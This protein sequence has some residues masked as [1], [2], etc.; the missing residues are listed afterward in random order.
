[1]RQKSHPCLYFC[2]PGGIRWQQPRYGRESGAALRSPSV[3]LGFTCTEPFETHLAL[4]PFAQLCQTPLLTPSFH[5]LPTFCHCMELPPV[6]PFCSPQLVISWQTP[7]AVLPSWRQSFCTCGAS[8]V[9]G[10]F[11]CL[12]VLLLP[13]ERILC[14]WGTGLA[15]PQFRTTTAAWALAA[16][17]AQSTSRSFAAFWSLGRRNLFP[18]LS[19]FI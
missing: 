18:A 6:A 1:M 3:L 12:C 11:L 2:F 14:G 7:P 16:L 9:T 10:C 19:L 13:G 8:S 17:R 5:P 15:R 4:G